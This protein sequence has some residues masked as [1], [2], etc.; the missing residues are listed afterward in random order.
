MNKKPDWIIRKAPRPEILL[1]M[2]KLFRNL[3]IH[4]ICE[5]ALCPNIGICFEKK[6]ATFLILGNI[7]S[8]NCRFCGVQKGRPTPV[9]NKEPEHVADAVQKLKLRHVVITSVTRDD[10][11]DF[12]VDQFIK[13]INAIR[14][15][16]RKITIEVLI[17]DFQGSEFCLDKIIK[18]RPEIIGHNIETIPKLYHKIRPKA[19][20][21]RSIGILQYL[22][23]NRI[24]YLIK[25]G[26][27]IGLGETKEE[28]FQTMEIISKTG[29]D[30]LTIGQYLQ[31]SKK[32][33]EV[34]KYYEPKFFDELKDYGTSIGF[35][36]VYSG[37]FIRSSFNADEIFKILK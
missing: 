9:D 18:I 6:V 11:P 29:C 37:P 15:N 5:N 4:T 32:Q 21:Y 33:V 31:P 8:R 12:G 10:L 13:T 36:Y 3:K 30:I 23:D 20:F 2:N 24:N 34:E 16:N 25:S 19:D 35:K 14:N 7:C 27:M 28:I 22:N 26:L 17:P 1:E